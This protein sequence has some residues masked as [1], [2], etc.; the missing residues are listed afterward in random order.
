[1]EIKAEVAEGED[2][3]DAPSPWPIV[4][5]FNHGFDTTI[6]IPALADTLLKDVGDKRKNDGRWPL[7]IDPS[8]KT[9]IFLTYQSAFVF[10]ALELKDSITNP[11]LAA[12]IRHALLKALMHGGAFIINLQ[13]FDFPIET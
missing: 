1:M 5:N 3:E 13:D 2:P 6:Q 9:S 7:V 8:G 11:E 4:V 12:R 10:T